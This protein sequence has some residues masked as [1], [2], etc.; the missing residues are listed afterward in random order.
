MDF[1]GLSLSAIKDN[2]K[3]AKI[4][5]ISDEIIETLLSDERKNVK[6]FGK[7]LKNKKDKHNEALKKMH[8]MYSFD[9]SYGKDLVICGVDEVGRGPLAGPIVG[10]AVIVDYSNRNLLGVR[11]SKKLTEEKREE[12]SEIIK[13]EAIAYCIY[14]ISEKD[15]DSK[16]IGYCNNEVLFRA[17]KGLNRKVDLVL[18]DGYPVKHVDTDNRFVIKGDD[19]SMAIACASILAKVYRDNL[20]KKYSEKYPYYGFEHNAGYGTK[21]HI[22]GIKEYGPCDIHRR[23]FIKNFI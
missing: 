9:L 7:T 4:E 11:D 5:D 8:L 21:D 22:E 23:S 1:K 17:Y 2:F 3:D 18:S 20:M 12:L 13:K 19:K 10:A 15:I 6:A 16:G 14:E